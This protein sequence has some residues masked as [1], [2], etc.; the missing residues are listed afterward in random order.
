MRKT[1]ISI[2]AILSTSVSAQ[3]ITLGKST[4][5]QVLAF[6]GVYKVK[7]R[8]GNLNREGE[9]VTYD[10][11]INGKVIGQILN[12]APK[13]MRDIYITLKGNKDENKHICTIGQNNNI[14]TRVC[15]D[16]NYVTLGD[17]I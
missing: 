4:D 16:V 11:S 6:G 5:K 8:V 2:L 9:P 10:L 17:S 1:L 13:E 3:T 15:V 7:L 12:V 14:K